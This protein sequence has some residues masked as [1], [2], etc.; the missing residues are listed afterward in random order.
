MKKQDLMEI[1]Q[2]I[3]SYVESLKEEGFTKEDIRKGVVGSMNATSVSAFQIV[4]AEI[5]TS[6]EN[7]VLFTYNINK[8]L[9][10]VNSVLL[11]EGIA[12]MHIT[13]LEFVNEVLISAIEEMTG[14][15]IDNVFLQIEEQEKGLN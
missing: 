3:R 9:G 11:E 15:N 2:E 1:A 10:G 7:G 5:V 6:M 4:A 12:P 13:E 14:D 8:S